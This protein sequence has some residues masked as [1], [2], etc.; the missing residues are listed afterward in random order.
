MFGISK[1]QLYGLIAVSFILGLL[2]I[3]SAGVVRGQDKIKR[4]L[5]QKLI[6]D[7]RTSKEIDDEIN[8]LDD[9]YLVDR[10]SKW[11]R[12]DNE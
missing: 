4:K 11:V 2:G 5:D 6:K 12:K 7:M 3:Y 1:L 9:P 10:A 8:Q